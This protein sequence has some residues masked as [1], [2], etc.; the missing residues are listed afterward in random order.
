MST[1][2]DPDLIWAKY[3]VDGV[4]AS[5][6]K[7]PSK[8]EIRPFMR[9]VVSMVTAMGYA[10]Y[11]PFAS[12]ALM[13]ADLAHAAKTLAVVYDGADTGI[14]IKVGASGSGSWSKILDYL[15][16]Y[17]FV[18]ATVTGGTVNAI[19]ATAS[20]GVSYS[21]GA[22]QIVMIAPG[23]TTASPATVRFDGGVVLRIRKASGAD[24]PIGGIV[25]NMPL[26]G[27]INTGGTELW[28]TNDLATAVYVAAAEAAADRAEDARDVAIAAAGANLVTKFN[29]QASAAAYTISNLVNYI[30]VAGVIFRR[31][32]A[33]HPRLGPEMIINGNMSSAT[34]WLES[35]DTNVWT[36]GSGVAVAITGGASALYRD[37]DLANGENVLIEFNVVTRTAGAVS[38]YLTGSGG[39]GTS[40]T[41]TGTKTAVL[42]AT[43][44][45]TGVGLYSNGGFAGTCDDVSAKLLP[46]DAFQ[47]HD[48][49]W[50]AWP[51]VPALQGM[52]G[53][54]RDIVLLNW[55]QSNAE[56]AD[57]GG[58]MTLNP[59]V[60]AWD[61]AATAWVTADPTK[62]PFTVNNNNSMVFHAAKKIQAERGGIV[63]IFNICLGG[64]PIERWI[65]TDATPT[66]WNRIDT[67]V[68]AGLAACGLSYVDRVMNHHGESN[69]TD[70]IIVYKDKLITVKNQMKGKSWWLPGTTYMVSG[71]LADSP[72][73]LQSYGQTLA[74]RL[75]AETDPDVAVVSSYGIEVDPDAPIHFS[76]QGLVDMGIRY[77]GAMLAPYSP[78]CAPVQTRHVNG[79]IYFTVDTAGGDDVDFTD[80]RTAFN[81]FSTIS[82]GVGANATVT[83]VGEH[84]L[85]GGAALR[86]A[87]QQG[88]QWIFKGVL[89][90]GFVQPI[91]GNISADEATARAYLKARYLTE[92][93]FVNLGLILQSGANGYWRDMM[94]T[95]SAPT[96]AGFAI[97]SW[98]T[99]IQRDGG[100]AS[101][102]LD[103]VVIHGFSTATSSAINMRFGGHFDA[104]KLT[105]SHCAI[106]VNGI[107][108]AYVKADGAV[109]A[110]N[111][112]NDV[113]VTNARGSVL[114]ATTTKTG[115][116]SWSASKGGYLDASTA[117]NR[118][119]V[120]ETTNG[121]VQ[122]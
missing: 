42:T 114:G 98:D 26:Q 17:Q 24:I 64:T 91:K 86:I 70:G 68:D 30:E 14:Y 61:H 80:L 20:P 79:H 13:N 31:V 35:G 118:A 76:G 37:P 45:T 110:H 9:W 53:F 62:A 56:G 36:I 105:V 89:V 108:N 84:T 58:D 99:Q 77:G 54:Q 15:P 69:N 75:A 78:H 97:S 41:T 22:Q 82:L 33:D 87:R 116:G 100:A 93:Q 29:D 40:E 67:E 7:Q 103:N 72:I 112:N 94:I 95:A 73:N 2:L 119:T 120:T 6:E 44:A 5:N 19:Q 102:R 121:I 113:R 115:G 10:N 23:T 39:I 16:G 117:E 85:V 12:K 71:E 104:S 88:S 92:I 106:A 21:D 101:I 59:N 74:I 18:R 11:Q 4:S 83:L 81:F 111:S 28:L 3:N 52:L 1:V 57:E 49:A 51:V 60:L 107:E 25:Q 43:G 48:G 90:G 8:D 46:A 32:E 47:S 38:A 50:W 122:T 66:M 34:G 96:A 27:Y 109:F 65:A 63:R 55:G